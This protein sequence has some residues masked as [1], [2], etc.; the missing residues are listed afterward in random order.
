[1]PLGKLPIYN[2]VHAACPY[3]LHPFQQSIP[4]R[5][6][7]MPLGKEWLMLFFSLILLFVLIGA[8]GYFV[9]FYGEKLAAAFGMG[10]GVFGVVFV[11]TVTSLPEVVSTFSAALQN[12]PEIG[13][14]NLLGASEYN[15]FM[16]AMAQIMMA[17]EIFHIAA[18]GHMI[19]SAWVAVVTGVA[20]FLGA[21]A[22]GGVVWMLGPVGLFTPLLLFLYPLAIYSVSRASPAPAP[23]AF[24][25]DKKTKKRW[26]IKY[27]I[28]GLLTIAGA[29]LLPGVAE[30]FA[31]VTHI[32]QSIAGTLIVA[33]ATTLPELA[34][35]ISAIRL[36]ALDLAFGNCLGSSLFNLSWLFAVDFVYDHDPLF[37]H[38][39]PAHLVCLFA[40][41]AQ[42]ALVLLTLTLPPRR[43]FWELRLPALAQI[44]IFVL[45]LSFLGAMGAKGHG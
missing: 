2:F 3:R 38:F 24:P 40:I 18:P 42:T 4:G 45:Y 14:G 20:G 28:A 31:Q 32:S 17:R 12:L 33:L 23:E 30:Q 9:S 10:A 35:T 41:A 5:K 39:T 29:A 37:A 6:Q 8:G 22:M 21:T 7:I 43:G 27:I 26:A 44:L 1:M 36:R 15:F 19:T 34:V 25:V 11:A 13:I 16:L